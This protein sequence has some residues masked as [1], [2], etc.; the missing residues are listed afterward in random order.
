MPLIVK[1]CIASE[2]VTTHLMRGR[3]I[4]ALASTKLR[5]DTNSRAVGS[6]REPATNFVHSIRFRDLR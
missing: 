2:T 6:N 4:G 5:R 3:F 1:A